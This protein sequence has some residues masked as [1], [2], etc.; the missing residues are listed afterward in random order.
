MFSNKKILALIPA[1]GGS[2]GIKDKNITLLNGKPLISYSIC[3]CKESKY[4]DRT[5][6]STDSD[7]IAKIAIKYGGDVP[8]MRPLE[9]ATDTAK[10]ID[11]VIHAVETLKKSG[12]NFDVVVLIQ[13]TQPLRLPY[14]IDR[15]IETFFANDER[16]VVSVCEVENH[17]LLIRSIENG[18]LKRLLNA[19]STCRR[20][21]MPT[22]YAVNGCVYVNKISEVNDDLSFNDN[23]IPYVMPKNR[24]VDIDEFADLALASYYL[25]L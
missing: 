13:A 17:P 18:K 1:R 24:S 22:Y 5:I 7:K 10:T 15:A 8:F 14:D 21:D 3:A 16:G 20:Q 4:I 11:V 23:P 2:K 9:L 19:N 25:N 12:D 6:I